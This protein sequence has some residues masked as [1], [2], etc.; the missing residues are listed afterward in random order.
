MVAWPSGWKRTK[1]IDLF[2]SSLKIINLDPRCHVISGVE[3]LTKIDA[4]LY[5]LNTNLRSL[6]FCLNKVALCDAFVS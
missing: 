3:L 4:A 1:W 2:S 6:D 5:E